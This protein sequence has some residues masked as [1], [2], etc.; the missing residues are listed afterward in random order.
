[1]LMH[2]HAL[3]LD[4]ESCFMLHHRKCAVFTS[5]PGISLRLQKQQ[6]LKVR[7]TA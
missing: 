4:G 2:E 7:G 1:M 3:P 5:Q 6:Q